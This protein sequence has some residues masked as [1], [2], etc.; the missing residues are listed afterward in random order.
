[1]NV[2][3]QHRQRTKAEVAARKSAA[4]SI[5][6][7][8]SVIEGNIYEQMYAQ[9]GA[10]KVELKAIE[11]VKAKGVRKGEFLEDYMAYVEGVLAANEP[12][13]DDVVMT[14]FIWAL[15]AGDFDL[16]L[17]IAKWALLHELSPPPGF[18]RSVAAILAEQI[19]ETALAGKDNLATYVPT[20]NDVIDKVSDHD[21]ADPIMAKLYKA[22]GLAHKEG[23]PN[24][25]LEYLKEAIVLN[26]QIGVKRDI[27][28]LERNIKAA[29]KNNVDAKAQVDA[30]TKSAEKD[31]DTQ[32]SPAPVPA[33]ETNST[34]PAHADIES[35]SGAD[36]AV[37]ELPDDEQ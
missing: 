10:H 1:M 19:A 17:R 28:T 27:E 12:V 8:Q 23:N 25:A 2:F 35:G 13:Q 33:T 31:K 26:S 30:E 16:S 29:A 18:D 37:N 9:M 20:L 14:I 7:R 24:K 15:D 34:E 11:S 21:M 5:E 3:R 22:A 32:A 6:G 36:A 4:T